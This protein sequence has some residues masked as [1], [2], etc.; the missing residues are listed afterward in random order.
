MLSNVASVVEEYQGREGTNYIQKN[1]P[2]KNTGVGSHIL[3]QGIFLTQ[4]L[5]LGLLDCRQIGK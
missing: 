4:V 3:L 5:S 2:G 1:S